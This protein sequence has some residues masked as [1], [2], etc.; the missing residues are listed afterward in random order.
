[1]ARKLTLDDNLGR[2]M[3]TD[4]CWL[5]MGPRVNVA[6]KGD[7]GL[8]SIGGNRWKRA[9]I[10][11]YE[12]LVGPVPEGLERRHVCNT[13]ACVRPDNEHVVPGT[14]LENMDDR[15]RHSTATWALTREQARLI[16]D[17]P[18][19]QRVVAAEYGVSPNTVG[20][21][22]RRATYRYL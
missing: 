7:Y 5:W 17:D 3:V 2:I 8:V 18:R 19:P 20:R 11:L 1:M 4:T 15:A 22:R 16:V 9:H 13:Y 10:W 14:H 21:L 12:H 6:G